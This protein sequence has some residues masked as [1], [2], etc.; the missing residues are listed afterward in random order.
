MERAYV[1]SVDLGT[2]NVKACLYDPFEGRIL[3]MAS[4]TIPKI[5]PRPGWI[6]QD[7]EALWNAM[8][9][10]LK[11]VLNRSKTGIHQV[12]A[13]GLANQRGSI[14]VWSKRSGKPLYNIITW[15]CRRTDGIVQELARGYGCVIKEKTG[16]IPS[17]NFS[18]PKIKWVI[19]NVPN[20]FSGD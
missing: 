6:E 20:I 1:V 9:L 13:I 11:E 16:L 17:S 14:V 10:V 8:L 15:Q 7:P 3:S 4:M 5:I 19:E 2:T 12:S 18:L